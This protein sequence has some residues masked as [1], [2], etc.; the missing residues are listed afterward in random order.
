MA[1]AF[2]PGEVTLVPP[3]SENLLGVTLGSECSTDSI[4]HS[5]TENCSLVSLHD[6]SNDNCIQSVLSNELTEHVLLDSIESIVV[7]DPIASH[8]LAHSSELVLSSCQEDLVS[9][10]STPRNL[11]DLVPHFSTKGV[12]VSGGVNDLVGMMTADLQDT[13]SVGVLQRASNEIHTNIAA[14][15]DYV[16][17]VHAEIPIG[18]DESLV[19]W[20]SLINDSY[21]KYIGIHEK[22]VRSGNFNY[23]GCRIALPTKLNITVWRQML[24]GSGYN[25][26]LVCDFLEFGFPVSYEGY[27]MPRSVPR[28]H[29]NAH[30]FVHAVDQFIVNEIKLGATLGP[31][32]VNP[33]CTLL[34]TSPLNTVPKKGSLDKRRVILDLSWPIG[35]SV[36][37]GIFKDSYIGEQIRITYPSVDDLAKLIVYFG[38]GCLMFKTDLARA[39]RQWPICPGDINLLGFSWRNRFFIDVAPPFGLRSAAYI[40]Q[41]I[42]NA[43][44]HLFRS[45]GYFGLNYLDDFG[46]V[47][48]PDRADTAFFYLRGL[49]RLL[50]VDEA[51]EKA[52]SPTQQMIFLGV[53][54]DT[55]TMTM[56]VPREKMDEINEV[57]VIWAGKTTA[58]KVETQ[59]LIG[60]LQFAA[61]CVRP[62]RVFISRM[63]AHLRSLHYFSRAAQVKLPQEFLKDVEWWRRFMHHYNGISLIPSQFWSSPDAIIATDACLTG[64]GG[65]SRYLGSFFHSVYPETI[66]SRSY[67]INILELLTIIVALKLWGR[68]LKG[69]RVLIFCDNQTSVNVINSGR[70]RDS[71]LGACLR[72]IAYQCA[73]C[74]MEIHACHISS[75]SNR[76]AD[77]LS[78]VGNNPVNLHRFKNEADFFANEIKVDVDMFDLLA[79]W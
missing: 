20:S 54:F 72:E 71:T 25:D 40:C 74:E 21:Y 27:D 48:T 16:T 36:N 46:G 58:S 19:D 44:V 56:A 8:D 62:G 70:T 18:M 55:Q 3:I 45:K 39:Y 49:L 11:V 30:N 23:C 9:H 73:T 47:D 64:C 52:V 31:F 28:N 32:T 66:L 42:T 22:V 41:R 60:R 14:A 10:I 2:S 38:S 17:C 67:D 63:L 6:I 79:A 33:L 1:S 75:E 13:D 77:Y 35:F 53:L 4:T 43:I 50:G 76:L 15:S 68:R 65:F 37:E 78:R 5:L 24:Q 59:S 12:F 61:K 29:S 7:G 26:Q 51:V 34:Y 69:Q 57:L